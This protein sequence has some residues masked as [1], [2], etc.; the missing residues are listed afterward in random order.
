MFVEMII[1]YIHAP[2]PRT[3][4]MQVCFIPDSMI[5]IY[6]LLRKHYHSA[7]ITLLFQEANIEFT[8]GV[9]AVAKRVTVESSL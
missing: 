8:Y 9:A 3:M 6:G 1:P 5:P 4:I 2:V 7:S